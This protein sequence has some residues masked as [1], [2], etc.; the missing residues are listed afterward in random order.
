[1][2]ERPVPEVQ[3]PIKRMAAEWEPCAAL[4]LAWPHN[5]E[6]WPHRFE[7]IE[8]FFA[9][10]ARLISEYTPVKVLAH[11]AVAN[12]ATG[13]FKKRFGKIP[14]NIDLVPIETND[15]WIRDYGPSY[16][17]KGSELTAVDWTYNAWGGKYP[18]WEDDD[19]AAAKIAAEQGMPCQ[20]RKLCIE[21]GA[22]ETDGQHRLLTFRDCLESNSRN[23]RWSNEQIV[24][25]LYQMLGILEIVWL[26]G[27]GLEGDDTDGH[28]DQLARFVDPENV[29]VAV[30]EDDSDRNAAGL[31]AN[32]RQLDLWSRQT[33]PRVQVHRL[34]IPAARTINE[35]RV[36]ESYCNFVRLGPS[37][38]IVPTFGNPKSDDQALGILRELCPATEVIDVD[39][40]DL[41]W[42]LG[43]LHCA[44]SNQPK[45]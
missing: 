44:S 21:G 4:W 35:T 34:P 10:L 30:C 3:I 37:Q 1:M 18:P 9:D 23:P 40:T 8:P 24:Q 36:P 38:M 6:T 13:H 29:V 26:D 5:Q 17:F 20:R 2:P 31:N 22:I 19:A 43:S 25:E 33:E 42:G 14:S 11:D 15:A 28:I 12:S 7:P 32:F 45:C 16:V 41:V 39:C 27:G